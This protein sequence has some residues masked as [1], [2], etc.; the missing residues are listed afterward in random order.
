MDGQGTSIKSFLSDFN[1]KV[2]CPLTGRRSDLAFSRGRAQAWEARTAERLARMACLYDSQR[3]R[4]E[5]EH[6][7]AAVKAAV[8]KNIDFS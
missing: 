7:K 8:L 3:K 5:K 1:K 4:V 2:F 6:K